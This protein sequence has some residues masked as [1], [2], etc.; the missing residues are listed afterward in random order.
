VH[1]PLAVAIGSSL[2]KDLAFD[3][4]RKTRATFPAHFPTPPQPRDLKRFLDRFEAV[5]LDQDSH[6]LRLATRS[7]RHRKRIRQRPNAY[8]AAIMHAS[9]MLLNALGSAFANLGYPENDDIMRAPRR[10]EWI[11]GLI[12]TA[13]AHLD[14]LISDDK[15]QRAKTNFVA[16]EF[17]W[18]LR[19]ISLDDYLAA[20]AGQQGA[21][22]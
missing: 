16:R 4:D 2:N 21:A 22:G 19:A 6:F 15:V 12:A 8:K 13:C 14:V 5:V 9:Y 20:R 3:V 7:P 10:G 1:A 18:S 17:S 11:D